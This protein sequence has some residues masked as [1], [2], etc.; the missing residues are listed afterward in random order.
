[1]CWYYSSTAIVSSKLERIGCEFVRA[2]E[3]GWEGAKQMY[4]TQKKKNICNR[5]RK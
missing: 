2:G 4:K 3:R 1:M 5:L